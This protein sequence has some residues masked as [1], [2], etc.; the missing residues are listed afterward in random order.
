[1]PL[2]GNHFDRR[3]VQNLGKILAS[4]KSDQANILKKVVNRAGLEPA[5][6]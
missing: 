3:V 1:M 4:E 6:R 2:A 5:T